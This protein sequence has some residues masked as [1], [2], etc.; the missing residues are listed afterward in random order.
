MACTAHTSIIRDLGC[1]C[2]PTLPAGD[3]SAALFGLFGW[4]G[5]PGSF[6]LAGRSGLAGL[7]AAPALP[8]VAAAPSG[9]GCEP[10]TWVARVTAVP[11]A[12]T[13][14]PGAAD[15]APVLPLPFPWRPIV[16][17]VVE[18]TRGWSTHHSASSRLLFRRPSYEIGDHAGQLVRRSG[19]LADLWHCFFRSLPYSPY[20]SSTSSATSSASSRARF[21][22]GSA[23]CAV[24]RRR[25]A[26]GA[27]WPMTSS[28]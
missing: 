12:L 10:R 24:R 5:L 14:L 3:G 27:T 6:D 8:V 9:V 15:G 22:V 13:I 23:G 19:R 28:N 7:A 26:A 18:F 25:F 1:A 2:L 20:T 21:S 11:P 17:T 16:I 4:L